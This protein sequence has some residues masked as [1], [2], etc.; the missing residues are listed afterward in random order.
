MS[1]PND[2]LLKI[3]KTAWPNL[4]EGKTAQALQIVSQVLAAL[5]QLGMLKTPRRKAVLSPDEL[6]Q[7]ERWYSVYPRRQGRGEG[8]VAFK[9]ALALTDIE[10]LCAT[11]LVYG[12][13]VKGKERDKIAMPA[14]WLNGKRWLDEYGSPKLVDEL[15]NGQSQNRHDGLVNLA[16]R[17]V[18]TLNMTPDILEEAKRL[19]P[20]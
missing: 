13:S 2:R 17:G 9:K 7:F 16:R 5:T 11:V 6:R 4:T 12:Q 1:E 19:G 8:E 10:T 20:L 14:T 15:T 18:H 3:A